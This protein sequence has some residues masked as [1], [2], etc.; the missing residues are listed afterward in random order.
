[1]KKILIFILVFAFL[2]SG[3]GKEPEEIVPEVPEISEVSESESSKP[4]PEEEPK[5]EPVEEVPEEEPETGDEENDEADYVRAV[6]EDL[7][8][9]KDTKELVISGNSGT[10]R[11]E[12]IDSF[13]ASVEKNEAAEVCGMMYGYTMPYYFELSFE[14]GGMI[15][16]TQI[17]KA[18]GNRI[19]E[20][21]DIYEYEKFFCFTNEDGEKFS[22]LREDIYEREE[23][24]FSPE[25]DVPG[26]PVTLSE[27]KEKAK[28]T[29]L[30]G[31][32]YAELTKDKE[33]VLYGSYGSVLTEDYSEYADEY[34]INLEP[35]C[36][37][38]FDVAGKPHY[39]IY[40]YEGENFVGEGYYVCADESEVVFGVSMV[41][42]NLVPIAYPA[43]PR[44]SLKTE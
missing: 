29:M 15:K 30:S 35:K 4:L 11:I 5:E 23:L 41:D 14:P 18:L 6:L 8:I 38:I 21:S 13:V 40:F 17:S 32:G 20:F 44:V 10:D 42:G 16:H 19:Q 31:T 24:K 1:M 36:E 22:L 26:M 7:G 25:Q 37:G 43:K 9:D 3:C 12:L 39:L 2:L 27:A 33:T 28:R 34:Y